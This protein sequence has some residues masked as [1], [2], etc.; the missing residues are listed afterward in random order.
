[1]AGLQATPGREADPSHAQAHA[2][3][4]AFAR[5]VAEGFGVSASDFDNASVR[6]IDIVRKAALS[7]D[8][9]IVLYQG[10]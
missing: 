7:A 6:Y 1:M 5:S 8:V 10:D 9:R 2:A 4:I 3:L